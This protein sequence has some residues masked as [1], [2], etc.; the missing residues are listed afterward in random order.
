MGPPPTARIAAEG[1]TITVRWSATPDDAVAIGE[2]LGLM[3]AGSV[4]A[5][6]QQSAAQA[7]PSARDE[8][9]FSASGL[10]RDYVAKRIVAEQVGAPC[11]QTIPVIEDFVHEGVRVELTCPE[12]VDRAVVGIS[13]LLDL[14]AAY[15]TVAVGTRTD[16]AQS[17][18]TTTVPQHEWR[19]GVDPSARPSVGSLLAIGAVGGLVAAGVTVALQR[20]RQAPE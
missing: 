5:Y 7:A 2:Q 9:R 13:M 3:P 18:F 6:R 17:V 12:P 14:S 11:S 20:R 4:T 8:A 16:P 19:F 1:N 10:L 15:R